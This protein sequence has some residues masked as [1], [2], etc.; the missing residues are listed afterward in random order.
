MSRPETQACKECGWD[1]PNPRCSSKIHDVQPRHPAPPPAPAS[2]ACNVRVM[3]P[4]PCPDC[5]GSG[6]LFEDPCPLCSGLT[7]GEREDARLKHRRDVEKATPPAPRD[8]APATGREA[9]REVVLWRSPV[10][11]AGMGTEWRNAPSHDGRCERG[12]WVPA[13][14]R[15]AERDVLEAALKWGEVNLGWIL[16]DPLAEQ[17]SNR[18]MAAVEKYA[19]LRRGERPTPADPTNPAPAPASGAAMPTTKEP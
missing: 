6:W 18:L 3:P 13:A 14:L 4:K 11:G 10:F 1:Q 2:D 19:A 7:P 9:E 8:E 12:A 17:P 5:D 16:G 15:A